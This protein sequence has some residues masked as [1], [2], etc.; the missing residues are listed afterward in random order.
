[1][2]M[3]NEVITH[4]HECHLAPRKKR[5]SA[6]NTTGAQRPSLPSGEVG[7]GKKKKPQKF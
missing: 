1:M 7:G 5:D 3:S 2:P 6:T 4:K